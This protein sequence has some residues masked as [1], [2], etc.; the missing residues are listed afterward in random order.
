MWIDFVVIKLLFGTWM[1]FSFSILRNASNPLNFESGN[2]DES[3]GSLGSGGFGL[4]VGK[5]FG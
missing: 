5:T 1:S 4:S 2:A 3:V